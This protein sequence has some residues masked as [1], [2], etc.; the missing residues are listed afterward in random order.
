M[1]KRMKLVFMGICAFSMSSCTM[2]D[3]TGEY[4][5]YP[6][7]Y[8]VT[9]PYT[10]NNYNMINYDYRYQQRQEVVVPE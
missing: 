1:D 7:S 8:D 5:A 3:T 9:Q 2:M 4:Q 10:L 6:A